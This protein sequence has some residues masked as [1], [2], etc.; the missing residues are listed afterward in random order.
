MDWAMDLVD[1]FHGLPVDLA[2]GHSLGGLALSVA[3]HALPVQRAVF[4]DPAWRMGPEVSARFL[5]EW[6]RWLQW[7]NPEQLRQTLGPGWSD[8]DI[9]LRWASMWLADAAV[10]PGLAVAGG[11]DYSPELAAVPTLVLAADP[12]QYITDDH[13]Q[14]L[15]GRGVSVR[16][17]AGSGHSWFR[18]DL[19]GFITQLDGWLRDTEGRAHTTQRKP[20]WALPA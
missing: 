19:P 9:A 6:S 20:A 3:Q 13:A 5:A 15:R 1:T 11:Y 2:I 14:D 4:L 16:V 10:I 7:T 12:S 18:E 17:V 8:E